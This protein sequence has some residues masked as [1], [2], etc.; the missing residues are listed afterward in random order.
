MCDSPQIDMGYDISDYE[1]IYPP[2]GTLDDMERLIRECDGRGMK[3]M[4]DW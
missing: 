2:Y 3:M 4:L 1:A